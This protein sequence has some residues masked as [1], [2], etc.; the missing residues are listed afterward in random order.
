MRPWSLLLT[1]CLAVQ[2]AGFRASADDVKET[3][4][5]AEKEK[6]DEKGDDKPIVTQHEVK[7]GG[8]SIKYKA[9]AGLMP[10]YDASDKVEAKM[11]FVAYTVD[12]KDDQPRRPLMF[13]FNGGPGS[14]SVWLHLG[15]LGPKRVVVPEDPTIPPPPYQLTENAESWLDKTDLVFI[16]PV[17]TGYS[18]AIK[19]ESNKKFHGLHGDIASVSEFI[20]MY[21][22]RYERWTSPLYLVGESYGTTRAAGLAG[23]LADNGIALNG[24]ILIST[25]LDFQT[26]RF[27]RTNE[28]PYGLFLPSY[29][30]TAWYHKKLPAELQRLGLGE[31]VAE[32]AKW[33][34]GDYLA[35]LGKGDRLSDVE[36]TTIV[37]RLAHY[38]GL[39]ERFIDLNELR[40]PQHLFSKEL[41]RD[42]RKTVGRF[43][44]RYLGT[45]ENAGSPSPEFDPS[46]AAVRPAYTA[47][48][49]QYVRTELNY[50]S[51]LP[52][53]ILGGGQI[54]AWD[55]GTPGL[56][57]PETGSALREAMGKNPHL[58]VL[59]AS[60]Y[61]DLATPFD[62]TDYTLAHLKLAAPLRKNV[63]VTTYEA[64]HMM[65][66][67]GPSLVKLKHDAS[68]F[69]DDSDGR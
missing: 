6:K 58:K 60:G 9:T 19:P 8:T 36:R 38:T 4:K 68:E 40:I 61:L 18:R 63:R 62:A 26:I 42:E 32:V 37:K 21:L 13:A 66:L 3:P 69:I 46:E 31:L 35:A 65:Y 55:W 52:Y 25:V 54:G 45:V 47:T 7:V 22:S 51:D 53:H 67:H 27:G 34:E 59:V 20:R 5:A 50:K 30:A 10:L 43:D 33:A 2:S 17:E 64:G 28:L 1:S 39:S 48:F 11:F 41:L 16:D 56:G 57:Y 44:S 12:T 14:S 23:H 24:V 15:A 49:N 29:A